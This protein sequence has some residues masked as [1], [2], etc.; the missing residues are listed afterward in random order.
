MKICSPALGLAA[1]LALGMA[2][3]ASAAVVTVEATANPWDPTASGN[4]SYADPGATGPVSYAVTAGSKLDVQYLSGTTSEFSFLAPSAGASGYTTAMTRYG[5]GLGLSQAGSSMKYFPSYEISGAAG[6]PIH[7]GALIG[8]FVDSSGKVIGAFAPGSALYSVVAPAGAA[9]LQFG[10]NDD[11]Y[12]DNSGALLVSVTTSA[13]PE[14][15]TWAFMLVGIGG[16]GM[17]LRA[18]RKDSVVSC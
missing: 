13:V 10:I 18:G 8:D 1:A 4:F 3:A 11:R 9:A 16:I 17:A 5:T 2:G 12:G 14:A 15:A 6:S 7:L